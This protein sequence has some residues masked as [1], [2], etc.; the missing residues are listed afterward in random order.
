MV[1]RLEAINR[2][3]RG[4]IDGDLSQRVAIRDA[5]D[6]FDELA[7]NLNRMLDRIQALMATV[8]GV[9]DNVVHDLRTPMARSRRGWRSAPPRANTRPGWTR[10]SPA[11]IRSSI[12]SR[13]C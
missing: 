2:T 4:I 6:E 11:S 3:G 10:R 7:R 13:P 8:K 9:S 5:D 12:P 1:R